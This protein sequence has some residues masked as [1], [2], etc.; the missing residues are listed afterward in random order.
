VKLLYIKEALSY[1][2]LN[3]GQAR[4]ILKLFPE[5]ETKHLILM[6]M[7][8]RIINPEKKVVITEVFSPEF[9]PLADVALMGIKKCKHHQP[10]QN[11]ENAAKHIPDRATLVAK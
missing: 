11:V 8:D 5:D 10:N 7:R 1:Q 9:V 2:A 6:R 4:E 3:C